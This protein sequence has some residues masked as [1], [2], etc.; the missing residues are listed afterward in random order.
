MGNVTWN[1]APTAA[2]KLERA[3]VAQR[4][5]IDEERDAAIVAGFDYDF[6]GTPDRV[7]TRDQDRENLLGLVTE[8]SLQLDAGG[9]EASLPF[10]AESDRTYMLTPSQAVSLG[11]AA[12]AHKTAQYETSW[13]RKAEIEAADTVAQVEAVTWEQ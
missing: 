5:I 6:D 3:K 9:T 12:M 11:R 13:T 7:Q 1:E 10:R 8:A 4:K 2:E